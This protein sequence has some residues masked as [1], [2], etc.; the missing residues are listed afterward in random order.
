MF[1]TLFPH[2]LLERGV[3]NTENKRLCGITA[4]FRGNRSITGV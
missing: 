2:G 3:F 1:A 4:N